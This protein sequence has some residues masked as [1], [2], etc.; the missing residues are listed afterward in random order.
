M[1]FKPYYRFETGCA[2]YLLGCGGLGRCAVVDPREEDVEDFVAFAGAKGMKI[3]HVIETHVHADHRSGGRALAAKTGAAYCLHASAEVDFPYT[4]L[5]DGDEVEL[6]NTRLRVLHTPGHSPES[7]CLVVTDLRRGPEPWFVLTGDTLFSG[8]V[9][10]PDLPG[11]AGRQAELLFESLRKLM[12]LPGELE[13]H[14]A[15]FM[16]SACGAGLSG[17]PS[18]TLAFERRFNPLLSLEKAAF[19]EAVTR[20]PAKPADM[21]AILALNAGRA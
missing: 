11:D 1:I 13:V 20:V 4:P 3:T 5:E 18:S 15:H 2:A 16:G 7:L 19:V 8:A 12:A 10:R 17:K 21:T 6:G 9:G 14:P